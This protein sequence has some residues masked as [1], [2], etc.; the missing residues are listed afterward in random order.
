MGYLRVVGLFYF[1]IGCLFLLYGLFRAVKRPGVSVV[2][3]VVSLG[4]R[5]ALAYLLSRFV[6][7]TG[8]W[9]SIPIG[10]ILADIVGV[11]YYRWYRKNGML[12]GDKIQG[13]TPRLS[14]R[15]A[16]RDERC[17]I[18]ERELLLRAYAHP[19]D[20]SVL[21][22]GRRFALIR[23]RSGAVAGRSRR[24]WS[25]YNVYYTGIGGRPYDDR[26]GF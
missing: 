2:L 11:L 19:M 20:G 10:W 13:N 9:A 25:A 21:G 26:A 15:R 14:V 8:I 4:T 16:T 12:P 5:V 23:R 22:H 18:P 3:T 6:G 7:V 17:T 1:G 24:H